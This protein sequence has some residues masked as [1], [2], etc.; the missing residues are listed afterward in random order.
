MTDKQLKQSV[1]A[2]DQRLAERRAELERDLPGITAFVQA[3]R[4]GGFTVEG[5]RRNEFEGYICPPSPPPPKDLMWKKKRKQ[6][7]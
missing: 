3:L 2:I 4:D 6:S 5:V 7:R 1:K